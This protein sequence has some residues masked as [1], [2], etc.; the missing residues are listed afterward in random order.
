M[1]SLKGNAMIA[2][3]VNWHNANKDQTSPELVI[4]NLQDLA[5]YEYPQYAEATDSYVREQVL[6]AIFSPEFPN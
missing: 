6:A 5:Y 3:I 2:S 4:Q 1:F